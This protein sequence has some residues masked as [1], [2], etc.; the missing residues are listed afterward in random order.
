MFPPLQKNGSCI[1]WAPE[2]VLGTE[3]A[4]RHRGIWVRPNRVGWHLCYSLAGERWPHLSF[5][6]LVGTEVPWERGPWGEQLFKPC[7]IW[8]EWRVKIKETVT[9]SQ[10]RL[11]KS[12]S[13][14]RLERVWE[15]SSFTQQMFME[16]CCCSAPGD[17]VVN[18]E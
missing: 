4:V 5:T 18:T 15:I 11:R 2:G 14:Q 10:P 6:F 7:H 16:C 13:K 1:L 9:C 12:P 3:T 17:L 8:N